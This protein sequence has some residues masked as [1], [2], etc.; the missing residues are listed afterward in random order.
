MRL[1][2]PIV[3]VDNSKLSAQRGD[4]RA[5][6]TKQKLTKLIKTEQTEKFNLKRVFSKPSG[7]NIVV[8]NFCLLS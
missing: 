3:F 2:K 5:K 1:Q 8:P 6:M 4:V 7:E